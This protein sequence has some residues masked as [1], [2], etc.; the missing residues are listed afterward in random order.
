[1]K[2]AVIVAAVRSPMGKA[3]KGLLANL[4]I[5]DLAAL[6]VKAALERVPQVKAEEI[7]DLILG[8]AMPEGEQGM[9][10]ARNVGL[11]AGLPR[12]VAAVTTNR[13][14]VI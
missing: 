7:E 4:R 8:C 12:T 10:L 2:E 6:I 11:L 5:D 13:F 9:N 14:H 1:M 3:G